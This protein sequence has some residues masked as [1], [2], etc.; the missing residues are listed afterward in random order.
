MLIFLLHTSELSM[1]SFN[2][3][4]SFCQ[5]RV[6]VIR[7]RRH[8]DRLINTTS[9][10]ISIIKLRWSHENI[11]IIVTISVPGKTFSIF[12]RGNVANWLDIDRHTSIYVW[13]LIRTYRSKN[14][15]SAPSHK[16]YIK[17]LKFSHIMLIKGLRFIARPI[18]W[19]HVHKIVPYRALTPLS[20]DDVVQWKH[21]PR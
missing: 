2:M 19:R 20:H 10:W 18:M 17:Y 1:S 11:T 9:I 6:T 3:N 8:R 15:V 7:K 16:I 14:W 4:I 12:N 13:T 21:F 5:S